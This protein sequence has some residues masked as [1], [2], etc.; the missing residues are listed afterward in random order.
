MWVTSW[1]VSKYTSEHRNFCGVV[2]SCDKSFT[3]LYVVIAFK[4][5][6]E[7]N[8][9]N[10]QFY[11]W[12]KNR[13]CPTCETLLPVFSVTRVSCAELIM[14]AYHVM[15]LSHA[16]QTCKRTVWEADRKIRQLRKLDKIWKYYDKRVLVRTCLCDNSLYPLPLPPPPTC[17]FSIPALPIPNLPSLLLLVPLPLSLLLPSLLL[18]SLFPHPCS[19]NLL[20]P[21]RCSPLAWR[22]C[23]TR[24]RWRRIET[25]SPE[26]AKRS[27][28]RVS[29][30]AGCTRK[31]FRPPAHR[32]RFPHISHHGQSVQMTRDYYRRVRHVRTAYYQRSYL[33]TEDHVEIGRGFP[34]ARRTATRR[35]TAVARGVTTAALTPFLW[36]AWS[37]K[38]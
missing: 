26:R 38:W 32:R 5:F 19:C 31:T 34:A 4:I 25:F 1:Q 12:T 27:P 2:R 14:H 35:V 22:W 3:H 30:S 10:S 33:R 18:L 23:W 9:Q 7:L 8:Y 11:G 36:R 20:H 6:S 37:G 28:P 16:C 29:P 24:S 21:P 15:Q 13:L 17:Y